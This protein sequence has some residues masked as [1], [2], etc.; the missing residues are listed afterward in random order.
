MMELWEKSI[1]PT[2]YDYG[3]EVLVCS[4]SAGKNPDNFF[5]NICTDP[6]YGFVEYHATTIDNPLL[7]KRPL[8]ES[9]E[10]W[11]A[12]R[13]RFLMDL[14]KNNDP[15]VYA[16]EHLAEFVDWAGVS[17]F[18]REK[19]LEDNR[20]LPYPV[21]RLRSKFWSNRRQQLSRQRRRNRTCCSCGI[22]NHRHSLGN[23]CVNSFRRL[24]R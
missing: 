12:R 9:P 24:G 4:N 8:S 1:K 7:P 22:S 5:Y 18:A 3:G 15:L 21:R 6:Q 10:D 19:L 23:H 20:P 17:F 2:L 16:Q 11:S 13:A 14:I